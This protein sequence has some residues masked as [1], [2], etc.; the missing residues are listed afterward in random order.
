MKD[1]TSFREPISHLPKES[2]DFAQTFEDL[3]KR[4]C[5]IRL[6]NQGMSVDSLKR[7]HVSNDA[8]YSKLIVINRMNSMLIM[9]GKHRIIHGLDKYGIDCELPLRTL[10]AMNQALTS[11]RWDAEMT[12]KLAFLD[13]SQID[14]V[15]TGYMICYVNDEINFFKNEVMNPNLTVDEMIQKVASVS[16]NSKK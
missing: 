7:I 6:M 8:D 4:D 16:D 10:G 2:Q 9:A 11:Y 14:V 15:M 1:S 13:E 12:K 3:D 5:V